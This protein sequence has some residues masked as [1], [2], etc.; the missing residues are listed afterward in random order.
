MGDAEELGSFG[1]NLDG[2]TLLGLADDVAFEDPWMT[3]GDAVRRL[4]VD[5]ENGH[6]NSATDFPMCGRASAS[7]SVRDSV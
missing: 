3:A 4:A 5:F 6:R 7:E 2:F 1:L